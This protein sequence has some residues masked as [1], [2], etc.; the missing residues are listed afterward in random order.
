MREVVGVVNLNE[1]GRAKY[2]VHLLRCHEPM[3]DLV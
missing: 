1:C 2:I 3:E